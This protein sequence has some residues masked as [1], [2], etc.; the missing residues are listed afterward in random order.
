[1]LVRMKSAVPALIVLA[2]VLITSEVSFAQKTV[3]PF[4]FDQ[5]PVKVYEGP[6][7]P[8]RYLRKDKGHGWVDIETGRDVRKPRLNFAGEYYLTAYTCG[9]CCRYYKMTNLRS[10]QEV[11]QA[12]MFD[13]GDEMPRTK[14]GHTYVPALY[15]RP[16]STLLIAQYSLD[17]C[18]KNNKNACRQRYFTFEEGQFKPISRTF[19]FCT[20]EGEEPE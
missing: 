4:Q 18:S 13:T 14:D 1:M 8:P 12:R 15:F 7:K 6:I 11:R 10:G 2:V 20:K 3:R 5:Y 16:N 17:L 19:G 9:T